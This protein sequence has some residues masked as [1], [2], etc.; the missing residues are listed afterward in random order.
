MSRFEYFLDE[1]ID[2]DKLNYDEQGYYQEITNQIKKDCKPWLKEAKGR[3][4]FRATNNV[5]TTYGIT[6]RKVRTTR[7]P[8]TLNSQLHQMSDDLF[9][10]KF[11]WSARSN[12]LF[13]QGDSEPPRVYGSHV[14]AIFPIGSFKYIWSSNNADFLGTSARVHQRVLGSKPSLRHID[15][16]GGRDEKTGIY[17][18]EYQKLFKSIMGETIKKDYRDTGLYQALTKYDYCEIMVNCKEY[19]A[20]PYNGYSKYVVLQMRK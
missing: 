12:V 18:K 10:E 14:W 2:H 13:L 9:K 1:A 4:G 19:Y 7:K 11:G 8:L 16:T 15:A 6:R 20:I 5:L 17:T 3:P